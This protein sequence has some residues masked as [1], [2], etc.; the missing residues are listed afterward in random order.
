VERKN[1]EEMRILVY[2]STNAR[3]V[4][5]QSVRELFVKIG[6]NV[7]LLSQLEQGPLHSFVS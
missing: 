7:W 5:L 1:D 3:A 6:Q 4:D 2:I